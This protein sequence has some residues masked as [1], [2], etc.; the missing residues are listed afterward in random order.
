MKAGIFLVGTELLNGATI[1]TNSIYIAE[2]V[3]KSFT[4]VSSTLSPIP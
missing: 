3:N 2:E 4:V 1:D